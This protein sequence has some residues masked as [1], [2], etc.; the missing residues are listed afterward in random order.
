MKPNCNIYEIEYG[1]KTVKDFEALAFCKVLG[2]SLED[3]Y[4]DTDKY[5]EA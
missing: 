4:S 1:K 5:Y 3:L 2:I